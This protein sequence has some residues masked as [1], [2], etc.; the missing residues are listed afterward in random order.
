M[1]M[2]EQK[3][4]ELKGQEEPLIELLE[5]DDSWV[6]HKA[7]YALGDIKDERAIEPLEVV[8]KNDSSRLARD[9]ANYALRQIRK[10]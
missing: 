9:A 10:K 7:A 2:F 8:A 6:R 3:F 1:D 4:E 5:D